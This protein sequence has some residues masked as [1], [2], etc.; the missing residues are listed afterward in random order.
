MKFI[1]N[2]M[3]LVSL[4]VISFLSFKSKLF[5]YFLNETTNIIKNVLVVSIFL[6][7]FTIIFFNDKAYKM[8]HLDKH[9]YLFDIVINSS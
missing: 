7:L 8:F 4:F 2:C 1:I 9:A 5:G 6:L 3:V